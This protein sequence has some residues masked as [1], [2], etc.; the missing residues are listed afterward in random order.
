VPCGGHRCTSRQ[1]CCVLDG[2]CI[3]PATAATTCPAPAAP[4]PPSLP[5]T[6]SCGSNADCSASEFCSP[7]SRC[8][9]PGVCAD[10]NNCGTSTGSP[11]CGCDGFNY[12][13]V[14]TACRLGVAT[15]GRVGF[16]GSIVEPGA[17]P[18]D[19]GP[20]DP[21]IYCGRDDQCP[22]GLTCCQIYGRCLDPKVPLLCGP[23][24]ADDASRPCLTDRQCDPGEFC[25]GD[26]C[27]GPGGCVRTP[28]STS[29]GAGVLAPVCGCDG[30]TYTNQTCTVTA[31]VRVL[32]TGSCTLP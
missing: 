16:C 11:W 20:H 21:I 19:P 32:H 29:C 2:T 27:S 18:E 31:G 6:R 9:G 23:P 12:A 8:L 10:R 26:G 5:G 30:Q 24:P 4:P 28:F 3:D 14:Q 7:I 13:D 22:A 17:F 1:I 25:E 15:L